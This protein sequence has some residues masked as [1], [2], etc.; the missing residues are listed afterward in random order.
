ME[1][2]RSVDIKKKI[3]AEKNRRIDESQKTRDNWLDSWWFEDRLQMRRNIGR[4]GN[5]KR[6]LSQLRKREMKILIRKED[7]EKLQSL[8]SLEGMVASEAKEALKIGDKYHRY[9]PGA[10]LEISRINNTLVTLREEKNNESESIELERML[11][12]VQSVLGTELKC[13]SK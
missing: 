11:D 5:R 12:L 6:I 10:L 2:L 8:L 3:E 13:K 4:P 7:E 1:G 9:I